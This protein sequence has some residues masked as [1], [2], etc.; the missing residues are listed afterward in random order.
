MSTQTSYLSFPCCPV[1]ISVLHWPQWTQRHR[2]VACL[3]ACAS[4]H[5]SSTASH[6]TTTKAVF[7]SFFCLVLLPPDPSKLRPAV[8]RQST[9]ALAWRLWQPWTLF[10]CRDQQRRWRGQQW[11][12]QL[13]KIGKK[14]NQCAG[15][16]RDILRPIIDSFEL[17]F[18]AVIPSLLW[19]LLTASTVFCAT[20]LLC[21]FYCVYIAFA[22][23][24]LFHIYVER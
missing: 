6:D 15:G 14:H 19:R 16:L 20:W 9:D 7:D 1:L 5:L 22:P 10:S 21:I 2:T 23:G 3:P 8:S 11:S 24:Y 13:A 12:K 4:V 17:H 18:P